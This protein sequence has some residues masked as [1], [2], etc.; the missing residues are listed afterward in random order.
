MSPCRRYALL[1]CALGTI[2]GELSAVYQYLTAWAGDAYL[3][4]TADKRL[5]FTSGVTFNVRPGQAT[6]GAP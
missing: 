4:F 6:R 3:Q 1:S 2:N 5:L